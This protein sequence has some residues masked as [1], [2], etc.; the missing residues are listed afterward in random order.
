MDDSASNISTSMS[1][2]NGIPFKR[3]RLFVCSLKVEVVRLLSSSV[4]FRLFA[5]LTMRRAFLELHQSSEPGWRQTFLN[6][7]LERTRVSRDTFDYREK[8]LEMVHD[9]VKLI[10]SVYI[11]FQ[12]STGNQ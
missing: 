8:D 4:S 9:G 2:R 1:G 10:K 12:K 11:L 6:G 3:R 5:C 7:I